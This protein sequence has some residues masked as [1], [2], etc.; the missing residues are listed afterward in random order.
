MF[1][2]RALDVKDVELNNKYLPHDKEKF[3]QIMDEE[4]VTACIFILG[5]LEENYS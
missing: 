1:L 3:A 2:S 5:L 4:S